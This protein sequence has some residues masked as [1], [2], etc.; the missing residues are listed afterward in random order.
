MCALY[1]PPVLDPMGRDQ[2][3]TVETNDEACVA[4]ADSQID[5]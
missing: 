5:V 3:E 4:M 2:I 1:S